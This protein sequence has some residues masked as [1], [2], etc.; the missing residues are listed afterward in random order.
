MALLS[1]PAFGP[2]LS[3]GLILLGTLMDVWALVW[4]FTL[5]GDEL[6]PMSRFFF[7]GILLTGVTLLLVGV[8]LGQIGRAARKAELPPADVTGAE[9]A[10]NQT[11][12]AHPPAVVSPA[13]TAARNVVGQ[14]AVPVNSSPQQAVSSNRPIIVGS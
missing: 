6:T 14:N 1:Q 11:A 8:F 5:G 4:R 13:G 2:K 9:V 3:I 12:A 7:T 10:I